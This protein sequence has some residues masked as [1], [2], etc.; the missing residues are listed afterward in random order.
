[1]STIA[2]T[3]N[4]NGFADE[5]LARLKASKHTLKM[6]PKTYGIPRADLLK[7][8]KG[9]DAVFSLLTEK[10]DDAVMQAAGTQLK[11]VANYAVGFDN[12]DLAAAKKRNVTVTN[13]PHEKVNEAVA[14]AA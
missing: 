8:V 3:F 10:I 2:I 7:L 5:A 4:P 6:Y 9:A 12:I 13:T 1:M 14:E 11:I